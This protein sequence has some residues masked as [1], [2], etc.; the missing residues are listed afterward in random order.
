VEHTAEPQNIAPPHLC[1]CGVLRQVQDQVMHT[2]CVLFCSMTAMIMKFKLPETKQITI[3]SRAT[4]SD[5]W[6]K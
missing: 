1:D 5:F 3:V 2:G 4:S 6:I